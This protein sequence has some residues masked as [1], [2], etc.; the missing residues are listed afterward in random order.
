MTL[1]LKNNFYTET[2]YVDYQAVCKQSEMVMYTAGAAA[3]RARA[4][5][6]LL[7]WVWSRFLALLQ[8]FTIMQLLTSL[9]HPHVAAYTATFTGDSDTFSCDKAKRYYLANWG[10]E[11]WMASGS[12]QKMPKSPALIADNLAERPC[13]HNPAKCAV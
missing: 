3:A 10:T 6:K 8:D 12:G 5:F 1:L 2:T 7:L 11:D 9:L 4:I 13:K